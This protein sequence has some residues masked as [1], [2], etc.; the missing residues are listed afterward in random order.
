[1]IENIVN[2]CNDANRIKLEI[3]HAKMAVKEGNINIEYFT[4]LAK[5]YSVDEILVPYWRKLG[6]VIENCKDYVKFHQ[7]LILRLEQ[8]YQSFKK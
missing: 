4:L 8:E 5:K 3:L 6:N 7:K 1:M 2:R